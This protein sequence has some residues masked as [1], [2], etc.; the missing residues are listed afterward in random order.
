MQSNGGALAVRDAAKHAVKTALPGPAGGVVAAAAI[1]KAAGYSDLLT[2][3]MGGTSTDV[4]LLRDGICLPSR[5]GW[6]R[7]RHSYAHAD[8]GHSH[9]RRRRRIHCSI[10][11]RGI[12]SR[13]AG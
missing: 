1:G 12:A 11:F 3:D 2:F 10:G 4:A 9:G 13:W 7:G 6:I 8:D 5:N